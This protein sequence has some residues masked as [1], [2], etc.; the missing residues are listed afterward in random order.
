[1]KIVS[2]LVGLFVALPA[3]QSMTAGAQSPAGLQVQL[4]TTFDYPIDGS[5]TIPEKVNDQGEIIGGV[6]LSDGTH[7]FL[8]LPNGRFS[9]PFTDPD[10]TIGFTIGFGINNSQLGCGIYADVAGNHGF[11]LMSNTITNYDVPGSTA[12]TLYGVNTD[13]DFCGSA[14]VDGLEQG[15]VS[16]AGTVTEFAVT[17]AT[18][19]IATSLNDSDEICGLYAD[20]RGIEHGFYR[21]PDGTIHAPVDP[22]GGKDTNF[23]GNNNRGIMVGRFNDS[24]GTHGLVFLPPFKYITYSYP[25]SNFTSFGGI[26]NHGEIVGR[27]SDPTGNHGIIAQLV[28]TESK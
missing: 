27:Y 28:P 19:T 24:S 20:S 26:N 18:F 7:G 23:F 10:D 13:N 4:I 22:R 14:T 21:D 5:Q 17:D 8:L 11:F 25:G 6:Q 16:L 2:I 12:T 1:M 3:T 9:Q 15:F